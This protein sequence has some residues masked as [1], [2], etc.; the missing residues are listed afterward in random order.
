M[1]RRQALTMGIAATIGANMMTATETVN[2]M[3]KTYT[4]ASH[5]QRASALWEFTTDHETVQNWTTLLTLVD[6]PDAKSMPDMDRLSQGIMDQYKSSGGQ[7]LLAKTMSAAGK[8]FNYMIVAFEQA[9]MRR[10]ELNFVKA[11]MGEANAQVAIYGVRVAA[12][13][14]KAFLSQNSQEIGMALEKTM[15]PAPKTLPR[16]VF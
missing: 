16:R 8:P 7:M 12:A 9:A 10:Y 11:S 15:F 5:N 6:R 14:A 4:L 1:N 3:G 2:F 13:Q